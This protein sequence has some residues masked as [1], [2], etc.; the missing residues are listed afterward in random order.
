MSGQSQDDSPVLLALLILV[1]G[2]AAFAIWYFFSAELMS[3]LRW[4]RYGE[5]S[6]IALI[7]GE[8]Y[9]HVDA[10]FGQEISARDLL[11][12]MGSA[13]KDDLETAHMGL[14]TRATMDLYKWPFAFFMVLMAIWSV[15]RGPGALY[16]RTMGLDDLI[17]EQAK[18]FPV[19]KPFVKYNPNNEPFRVPGA[20]VPAEL[21][22]FSEALSP[23]EFIAHSMIPMPDGQLDEIAAKNVFVQ[24]L[25]RRWKGIG[26]LNAHERVLFAIFALK[27]S[28][29]RKEAD[30]LLNNLALCWHPKKGLIISGAVKAQ[31][32]K[33]LKDAKLTKAVY[34]EANRHAYVKTAMLRALQ[35][36]R[37]KGGV[38]ASASFV[39]LRGHD[40]DLWY[41]LNN[42]G[43]RSFHA[44]AMGVMSHFAA[45]KMMDRAI[46]MPQVASAVQSLGDY[47]VKND[48]IVI[49]KL[50]YRGAKA[51]R[52]IMKPA[53]SNK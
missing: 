46:P 13:H 5:F 8:N 32:N 53:G 6:L 2:G 11:D 33:I 42:L 40:R 14:F 7:F 26:S 49:P 37:S 43:R 12:F 34:L 21:P 17:V 29:K 31:T 28:R 22:R 45:E 50:D 41:P 39:W 3:G 15:F 44:E 27:S 18:T 19:I 38:M 4:L 9:T 20:P 25:G 47:L 24:Q 16:H 30:D 52:G 48:P 36:A 10:A 35:Y 51:T 1:I 23:E